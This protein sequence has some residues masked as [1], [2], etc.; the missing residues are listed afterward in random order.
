MG[1]QEI[2]SFIYQF[3]YFFVFMSVIVTTGLTF[4]IYKKFQVNILKFLFMYLFSYTLLIT[5]AMIMILVTKFFKGPAVYTADVILFYVIYSPM[6]FLQMYCIHKILNIP[7][8]RR[9]KILFAAAS[10]IHALDCVRKLLSSNMY[11][12]DVTV[13]ITSL[14]IIYFLYLA[15]K[16]KHKFQNTIIYTCYKIYFAVIS[17]YILWSIAQTAAGKFFPDVLAYFNLFD[18]FIISQ[19]TTYI[20]IIVILADQY[21]KPISPNKEQ[22]SLDSSTFNHFAFSNREKEA[23]RLIIQGLTAKEIS[24]KM[25]ISLQ[26]VKNY[27]YRIYQKANVRSKVEFINILN[28]TKE[29]DQK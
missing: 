26:T 15:Y 9:K 1:F 27:T 29:W 28:Q 20:L 10:V 11:D 13:I 23:A 6:I 14:S 5:V 7:M 12:R 25:C 22:I 18:L 4:F 3:L 21:F 16:N 2:I 19:L 24:D 8:T 17:L